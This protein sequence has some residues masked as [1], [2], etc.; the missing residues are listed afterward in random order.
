MPSSGFRRRVDWSK[1]NKAEIAQLEKEV[2]RD[3]LFDYADD[4]I[5]FSFEN[6]LDKCSLMVSVQDIDD[7]DATENGRA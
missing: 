5:T 4:E 7:A 6:S 1:L 2:A 3:L